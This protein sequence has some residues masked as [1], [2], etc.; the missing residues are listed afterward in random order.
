M[1]K[2]LYAD[3]IVDISVESLD[4]TYQYRIPDGYDE[5]I[6]TGS[7]VIIPFGAGNRRINGYVVGISDTPAIDESK[8]KYIEDICDRAVTAPQILLHLAGWMKQRYGVSMNEAI[9]TVLPVKRKI[10]ETESRRITLA[11]DVENARTLLAGLK[12]KKNAAARIRLLDVLIQEG[13]IDYQKARKEYNIHISTINGLTSQGIIKTESERVY[14]NPI[15]IKEHD[16][17]RVILNDEQRNAVDNI[18][19]GYKKRNGGIYLL[20]GVTG[21]GKTEV[22]MSIIEEV[23]K[24]GRQVIMLIPEIALTYQTVERF[25]RRFGDRV[26]VLN[27]RMSQGERYDQYE[28]AVNN[29]IDIIVGPRS[30][31]FI[32]FERLGLIIIDEEHEDSYKSEMPPKYHAREVAEELARLH[33]ATLLMGS[34]TPS[35][36][37]YYRTEPDY[38][39]N[40]RII[41]YELKKRVGDKALPRVNIV[42][43]R[44]EFAERNYSALSRL[45]HGKIADRLSRR[46]QVMLFI[47]RRG[48]A[49]FVSCRSC[50]ES[51]QCPHCDVS[52]TIHRYRGGDRLVCHYCGYVLPAIRTCPKC[53]S[54]YIGG[55]GIGTQKIEEMIQKEFPDAT[56]LRMDSDT[57]TGK[58]GHMR[59]LEAFRR[60]E[61]DILIGTQMIVKGHDFPT[62]TL[63]GI[64]AADMTLHI[65]DFRSSEKTFELL[66]Q[67][68]GRAGRGEC[69]G[70][71]VIQTYKPEHYVVQC[72]GHQDYK[73]FYEQEIA[74]RSIMNYPPK[75]GL[76]TLFVAAYPGDR[77]H[78]I[79]ST[80][81][82]DA[83]RIIGQRDDIVRI[84]PA[85]HPISRANDMYRYLMHFKGSD[86]ATLE[87]IRDTI[88]KHAK[89]K[90]GGTDYIM[91]FDM[92]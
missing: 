26:S 71:V 76:M 50:G 87:Y 30:A 65:S 54:E 5:R 79:I 4:R 68:A 46:E 55:F 70:E 25:G 41:K 52:L 63:V 85:P 66:V 16:K 12:K 45:L 34:A 36:E 22:Y 69:P 82:S 92:Q 6:V 81:Q 20:H 21:S 83:D 49:G 35:V 44:K 43:M 17:N 1:C 32:P 80:A 28:R 14:R 78:D 58:E 62:V 73:E 75:A 59:I 47:N 15:N 31:L 60:H 38:P 40:D 13:S 37:T 3:I 57:T 7:R 56:L 11:T 90:Y 42:D 39:G 48:Y 64:I 18:V 33:N 2:K 91:Q 77:A 86:V 67:A 29:E 61:A 27:S 10:K 53:G 84:G 8:I 88:I 19:S 23:I 51:I 9:K 74:Y 89:E 72:A 24:D